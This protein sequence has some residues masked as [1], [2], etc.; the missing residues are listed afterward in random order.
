MKHKTPIICSLLSLS[1]VLAFFLVRNSFSPN[2]SIDDQNSTETSSPPTKPTLPDP[3]Y[4][5]GPKSVDGIGKFYQDRE[6]AHVMGHR[7]I[8]WLERPEREFEESPTRAIDFI[9]LKESDVIADIGAG[10]GYYSL[11]LGMKHPEAKVIAVDIEKEMIGFLEQRIAQL[12]AENVS[13]H[14]GTIEGINLP[15]DSIDAALMVDSYHEFSHPYEMMSSIV[16][17]LRPGGRVFLLEY[18]AED[19]TVPIKLLHKMTQ[20]QAKKEMALVGLEWEK[21]LDD[22]PWQHFMVFRKP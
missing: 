19:P 22:L 14:L 4:T 16:S 15:P 18:R 8:K 21:T 17:A 2:P 13:T 6:I 10:S 20:A 12:S 9:D 11:R 1:L 5:T 7:G 3:I